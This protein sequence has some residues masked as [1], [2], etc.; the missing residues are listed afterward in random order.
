MTI[1]TINLISR[2]QNR[3]KS[4]PNPDRG[5]TSHEGKEPHQDAKSPYMVVR[6]TS[7]VGVRGTSCV[8]VK[9]W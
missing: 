7:C 8:G 9:E 4:P 3:R 2:K 5:D 6:G 1:I